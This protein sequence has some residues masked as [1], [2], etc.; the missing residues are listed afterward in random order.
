[1]PFINSKVNVK[2]PAEKELEIKSA[3]GQAISCIRGKSE[4]WLMVCIEPEQKL[5]FQ[6][7][8]SPAAFVEVKIYGSAGRAEY[9]A[10][11]A[12]ITSIIN[13]SL[14]IAPGRI[15][16]KYEEVENWG[17]NGHNF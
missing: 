11:T 4:A 17:F 5:Y 9:D 7:N 1:M 3:L 13:S 16:V 6:G 8:D 15:Y 12:K 14:D 2:V 10:L